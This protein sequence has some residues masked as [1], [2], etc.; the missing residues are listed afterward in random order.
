MSFNS[1]GGIL[2]ALFVLVGYN[3]IRGHRAQ[4]GFLLCCSIY[5]YATSN[6]IFTGLLLGTVLV[7]YLSGIIIER[8]NQKGENAKLYVTASIVILLITLGIFKYYGFFVD[9][10]AVTLGYF[11]LQPTIP[12]LNIIL[13]VGI[14]FYVFQTI[15]YVIDV[16]RKDVKAEKNLVDFALFVS[17]FPQ[18]VAGPIE[19]S[20]NLLNQVKQPRAN[21]GKDDIIYGVFLIAQGYVK[22]VV[23][24]D[25]LA[26]Y[27]DA[28]FVHDDLS[29]PLIWAGLLMFAIQIYG[30]FSGYT[31]I[32]R[33]YSRLLGFRILLNFDRPYAATSPAN[34]WRRWHISLSQWF[35][36]YVYYSLGGNRSKTLIRRNYNVVATM[37]LSGLWHGASANFIVWGI[38]H[39]FL[40]IAGR[41]VGAVIP[42]RLKKL[43]V[44]QKCSVVVTF[45]LVLYGW[46]YFRITD[47]DQ[48][49]AFNHAM[50]NRWDGWSIAVSF[51]SRGLVFLCLWILIDYFEKY[52]L[53][54][55]GFEV[56]RRTGISLYIGVLIFLSLVIHAEDSGA[57]IYF[58]F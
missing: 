39:G 28:L 11:G 44:T 31:D 46:M 37:S 41:L 26:L 25:N 49:M 55:Y 21:V 36:D 24:A 6:A 17:F 4:N 34:F 58:R 57:F 20:K 29:S 48:I 47:F 22:K 3:L 18:L 16:Y 50:I 42:E 2:F 7:G 12:T 43:R 14:S 53:D 56:R 13:P 23:I 45:L 40:I 52:W 19:R 33:G 10:F 9:S 30:D 32:A 54:V 8:K 15:G 35:T 5:F 51:L 38:Y 27:V 1:Y